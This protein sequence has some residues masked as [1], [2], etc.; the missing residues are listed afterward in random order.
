MTCLMRGRPGFR[1]AGIRLLR[2]EITAPSQDGVGSDDG[3]QCK[4]GFSVDGVSLRGEQPTLV[5]IREQPLPAEL[6]EQ[7]FDLSVL[8]LDDLLLMLVHETA[9]AGQQNTPWLEQDG[10]VRRRNRPV[11]GGDG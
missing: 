9:E 2:D 5:V 1:L 11:S 7:C 3:G 6:F 10:H 8:E 4:Q